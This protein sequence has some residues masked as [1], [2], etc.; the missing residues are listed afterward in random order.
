MSVILHS[1]SSILYLK[2]SYIRLQYNEPHDL[3]IIYYDRPTVELQPKIEVIVEE[4]AYYTGEE[5]FPT[6]ESSLHEGGEMFEMNMG[7]RGAE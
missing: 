6:N 5:L 2:R 3:V 4:R 7:A 1:R